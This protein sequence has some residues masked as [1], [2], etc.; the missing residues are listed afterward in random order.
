MQPTA[1]QTV[2]STCFL[3]EID[4][5]KINKVVSRKP[6]FVMGSTYPM[7]KNPLTQIMKKICQSVFGVGPI[8]DVRGSNIT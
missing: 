5:Y 7:Q 4:M 8:E 1:Y 3:W 6:F 2:V